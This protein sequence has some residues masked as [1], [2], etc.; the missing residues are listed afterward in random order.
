[1][2]VYLDTSIVLRVLFGQPGAFARWGRWTAAFTS[3]LLGVEARRAVD[4]L[5]LDGALDDAGVIA[6]QDA[7]ART[8]RSLALVPISRAVLRRASLPLATPVRT[9]DAIHLATALLLQERREPALVFATHDE[10]QAAAASA[11]GF[12]PVG[13]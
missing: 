7:I 10:R 3:E 5:R 13:V 4:R 1:V 2:I 12:A 6:M 11:L 8:E 9:L